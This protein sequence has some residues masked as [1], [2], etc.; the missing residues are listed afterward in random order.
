M[1][2]C[3]S[4]LVEV[5]LPGSDRWSGDAFFELG[6]AYEFARCFPHQQWPRSDRVD[7]ALRRY[8]VSQAAHVF[9]EREF[10]DSNLAWGTLVEVEELYAKELQEPEARDFTV[11]RALL[12]A[13][14]V[15]RDEGAE[16]RLLLWGD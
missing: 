6:K 3:Y 14:R 10:A 13:A 7:D 5:K 4:V 11:C 9:H 8:D 2:T 1:G 12:A 15:F 16:V